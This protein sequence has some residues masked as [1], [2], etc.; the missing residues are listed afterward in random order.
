MVT[1]RNND[2]PG[3]VKKVE[4]KFWVE[5]HSIEERFLQKRRQRSLLLLGGTALLQFLSAIA[6]WHQDC[7]LFFNTYWCK[8]ASAARN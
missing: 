5:W 4:L 1:L 8:I 2:H 6:I 3:V 7:T